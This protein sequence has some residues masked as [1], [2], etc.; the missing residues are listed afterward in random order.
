MDEGETYISLAAIQAEVGL[1]SNQMRA[2]LAALESA[3]PPYLTVQQLFAEDFVEGH[4]QEISERA[5]RTLK[6]WPTSDDVLDR[7]VAAIEALA[8]KEPDPA[9][10][11]R[12]RSA[13]GVLGGMARDVVVAVLSQKLGT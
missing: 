5:R 10:K 4:V 9:E 2:G 11:S 1:E 12:L 13:A 3:F 8:D 6:T 7:L